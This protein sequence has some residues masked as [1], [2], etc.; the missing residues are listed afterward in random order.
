MYIE[1]SS[2]RRANDGAF[3]QTY[4]MPSSEYCLVINYNMFGVSIGI[5]CSTNV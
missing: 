5:I 3:L 4:L 2:P 1:A